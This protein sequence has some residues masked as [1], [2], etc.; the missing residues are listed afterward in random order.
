M[1]YFRIIPAVYIIMRRGNRILLLQRKNTGYRD[2]YFSLPAGHVDGG[3]K[4]SDAA[5]REANEE[6]GITIDATALRLVHVMHRKS[7]TPDNDNERLDCYFEADNWSGDVSNLEPG[8]CSSLVWC[9]IDELPTNMIPTV[10]SALNSVGSGDFYSNS[11][12]NN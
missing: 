6:L 1:N 10:K 7:D 3:E 8:K 12:W 4:L 5:I 9:A 11:G 2:G